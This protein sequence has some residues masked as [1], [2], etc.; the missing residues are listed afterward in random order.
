MPATEIGRFPRLGYE[1]HSKLAKGILP[2]S[3][4][5]AGYAACRH[6]SG[7]YKHHGNVSESVLADG[8]R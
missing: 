2:Q 6:Q 3:D 5:F 4:R 8:A 1:M 7:R